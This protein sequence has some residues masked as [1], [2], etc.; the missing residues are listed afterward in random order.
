MLF[1]VRAFGVVCEEL[2][3]WFGEGWMGE[4]GGG[5]GGGDGEWEREGRGEGEERGSL[6]AAFLV[7]EDRGGGGEG[8]LS[9]GLSAGG[10]ASNGFEECS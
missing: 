6:T 8:S 2:A 1:G 10:K 4:E 9:D 3:G 5:G 7:G